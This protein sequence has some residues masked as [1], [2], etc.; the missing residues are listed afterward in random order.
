MFRRNASEIFAAFGQ[1]KSEGPYTCYLKHNER[2]IGAFDQHRVFGEVLVSEE[3]LDT[4]KKL[5]ETNSLTFVVH[6]RHEF[7]IS[8]ITT[9]R[10]PNT[11]EK[12]RLRTSLPLKPN[13][14]LLLV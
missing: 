2:G 13:C 6:R 9:I 1:G 7:R 5:S 12:C 11:S 10:A 4:S 14:A 8:L 3:K